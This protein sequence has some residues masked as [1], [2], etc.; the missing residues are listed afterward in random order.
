MEEAQI[1]LERHEEA[2][3]NLRN[4]ISDLKTVQQEIKQISETLVQLASELKHTNE[5]LNRHERKIDE[6]EER[7]RYSMQQIIIAIVSALSG[8]IISAMV[9]RLF[10]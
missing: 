4:D 6:L 2:I 3:K 1:I 7:P 5:H 10:A 8:A 9:A